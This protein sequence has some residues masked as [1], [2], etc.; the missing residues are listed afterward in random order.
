MRQPI[1]PTLCPLCGQP[2]ACALASASEG[3]RPECWCA[4][5]RF[6]RRLLARLPADRAGGACICSRCQLAAEACLDAGAG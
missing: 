1:D 4:S 6:D 2:N 5:R 3:A